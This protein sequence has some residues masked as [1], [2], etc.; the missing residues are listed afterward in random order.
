MKVLITGMDGFIGKAI[1]QRLKSSGWDVVG[2]SNGPDAGRIPFLYKGSITDLSA[3]RT[4]FNEERPSACV[5]LA[6]LAH[7]TVRSDEIDLVRQVNVS[8]T[9]NTA[10]AAAET[11]VTQFVF[12][13][14]SKVYGDSTPLAGLDEDEEPKPVGIYAE[15]KYQAEQ[16][17]AEMARKGELG[18][19]V[20][21]PVAVFGRGD[22]RGNYAR[23]IRAVRKGVFPVIDG[24]RARR[25]IAYLDRVG[26]R[27][28]R[29]LGPAFV[30]GRTY[31]FSDGEFE[32]KEILESMRRATGRAFFPSVPAW[33][34][35]ASGG[36]VD[37]LWQKTTGK[38]GHAKEALARLTE[39][40]VVRAHHYDS[41][42]GKLDPFDL[43]LAMAETCAFENLD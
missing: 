4:V 14:S 5:H 29:I 27:I 19:V 39:N 38:E 28:D 40:F 20:I 7:A 9:L 34:A 30:S 16:E 3:L 21:R 35:K 11:G 37:W 31:V 10:K 12:F 24:G 32:L 23:L 43:D 6:G 36:M 13:S 33:F 15:A 25:S 22:S 18:V 1:S 42:F 2:F 41:D 17:L 26:E 8:G